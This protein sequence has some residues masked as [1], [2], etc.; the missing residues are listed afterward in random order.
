MFTKSGSKL[1]RI[2]IPP[3]TDHLP[4][5]G[6]TTNQ[7]TPFNGSL[8]SILDDLVS[9]GCTVTAITQVN[10]PKQ[11]INYRT[12]APSASN[13]KRSSTKSR[14]SSQTRPA[15]NCIS[16]KDLLTSRIGPDPVNVQSKNERTIQTRKSRPAKNRPY[17]DESKERVFTAFKA[18]NN[19][20][21]APPPDTLSQNLQYDERTSSAGPSADKNLIVGKHGLPSNI[22]FSRYINGTKY[23]CFT[24]HKNVIKR[25]RLIQVTENEIKGT[26]ESAVQC[27]LYEDE[28]SS[29]DSS[30][31][32]WI[33]E[34]IEEY[35]YLEED[36]DMFE[37]HICGE[38]CRSH[39]SNLKHSMTHKESSLLCF[40]CGRLFPNTSKLLAHE[41]KMHPNEDNLKIKKA[42]RCPKLNCLKAFHSERQLFDHIDQHTTR[43]TEQRCNK[44]QRSFPSSLQLLSHVNRRNCFR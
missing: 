22:N 27:D 9:R 39:I 2:S 15:K 4:K 33:N 31:S 34:I 8:H 18:K 38:V 44:C 5:N 29:S 16:S 36:G 41:D 13:S 43:I 21:D 42:L 40:R 32:D 12:S 19:P 37:C 14:S 3:K 23:V 26:I 10:P 6:D 7:N 17:V 25:E 1:V 11:K 28:G 35:E 24:P 20:L 30:Q